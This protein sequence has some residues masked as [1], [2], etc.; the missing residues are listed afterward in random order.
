MTN[1]KSKNATIS[2]SNLSIEQLRPSI[3]KIT[4]LDYEQRKRLVDILNDPVFVLAWNN[5]QL[6]RPSVHLKGLDT[7]LGM[8]LASHRLHE[9]RG[10]EYFS[11]AIMKQVNDPVTSYK[12]LQETYPD[13]GLNLPAN[14]K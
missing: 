11:A 3:P 9:L 5:A 4:Q 2:E 10:W 14:Q 12:Q 1:K 13:S 7:A 6:S 8:Q